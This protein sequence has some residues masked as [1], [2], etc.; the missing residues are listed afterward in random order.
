MRR[1]TSFFL[2]IPAFFFL[3]IPAF[4]QTQEPQPPTVRDAYVL[5]GNPRVVSLRDNLLVVVC[6]NEYDGWLKAWQQ[7]DKNLGKLPELSLYMN[8]QLMNGPTA[9]PAPVAAVDEVTKNKQN[10]KEAQKTE[11]IKEDCAKQ[12]AEFSAALKDAAE[13]ATAAKVAKTRANQN[14]AAKDASDKADAAAR[15]SA[16]KVDALQAAARQTMKMQFYLDPQFVTSAD[17]QANWLQLLEPLR[18]PRRVT[19]SVG[20]ANG[21]QWPSSIELEF[22]RINY[23]WLAVWAVLFV[24]A[25]IGFIR[26][27]RISNIIRDPGE[28]PPDAKAKGLEKAY[29]LA[30]TQAAFWTFLVAGALA[31]IFIVTCNQNTISSGVLVLMGISLGTAVMAPVADRASQPAAATKPEASNTDIASSKA[32]N[33][34]EAQPT[35]GKFIRDLLLEGPDKKDL[36]F[37]R[38]QMLLFTIILGVI[39]IYKVVT[40]LVMPEFDATLLTLMGISSG[41]YLGFKLQGK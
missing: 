27:A 3:L 8:G 21:S 17:T 1:V 35:S 16:A 29:S 28:L 18:A 30:R 13:K 39:F 38:F 25:L 41:T 10:A 12:S 4:G 22:E 6:K 37:H 40:T 2:L 32:E 23:W 31:F 33:S 9:L 5:F 7:T 14:A 19:V 11:E 24:G 20:L 36:S 26:Y 34:R 15:D